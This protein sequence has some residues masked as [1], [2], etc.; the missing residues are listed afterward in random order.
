[1]MNVWLVAGYTATAT[2][3]IFI[4]FH[5]QISKTLEKPDKSV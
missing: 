5:R 1:M 4:L 3:V 2:I